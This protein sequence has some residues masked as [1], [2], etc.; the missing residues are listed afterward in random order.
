M[1]CFFGQGTVGIN[2]VTAPEVSTT[3]FNV[4][5]LAGFKWLYNHGFTVEAGA[6]ATMMFGSL[7]GYASFGGFSPALHLS[8]GYTW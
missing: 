7:E 3:A 5:A 1:R 2:Y 6:G 8:L 4:G